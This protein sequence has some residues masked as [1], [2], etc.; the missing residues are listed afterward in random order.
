MGILVDLAEYP[1]Q[2][3]KEEEENPKPKERESL[4]ALRRQMK[5]WDERQKRIVAERKKRNDK[6]NPRK[7]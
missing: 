3:A 6:N 1:K 7:R 4:V 5:K 2:K